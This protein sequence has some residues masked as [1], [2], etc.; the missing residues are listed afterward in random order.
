MAVNIPRGT[1]QSDRFGSVNLPFGAPKY[2][3]HLFPGLEMFAWYTA[4]PYVLMAVLLIAT[5]VQVIFLA[6]KDNLISAFAKMPERDAIF[7]VIGAA[8][9]VG[10]FFTGQS[11]GYRGV[12]LIFVVAGLV[13]MRRSAENEAHAMLTRMVT[14]VIFLM[15]EGFFR[16]FV[17]D[18]R[19]PGIVLFAFFW[20]TR[21]ILWWRL[22]AV[23]LATLVIFAV[24]SMILA[25]S[26]TSRIRGGPHK[27]P[28]PAPSHVGGNRLMN[29][30]RCRKGVRECCSTIRRL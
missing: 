22:S 1:Y 17:Q 8:L 21:E 25:P 12:H 18:I 16:R 4:F 26:L 24:N 23:L 5:A 2:A 14:V 11:I 19:G 6:R 29:A 20:L 10:C 30:R 7:L 9:I 27:L 28:I 15:W 3:L 13:A